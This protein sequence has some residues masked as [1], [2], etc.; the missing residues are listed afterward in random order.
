VIQESP[1]GVITR[2][3]IPAHRSARVWDAQRRRR[4]G[5]LATRAE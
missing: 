5:N 1:S 2:N 4:I 3:A